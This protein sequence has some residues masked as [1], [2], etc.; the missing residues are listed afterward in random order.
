MAGLVIL[1]HF[2]T[3]YGVVAILWLMTIAQGVFLL[4]SAVNLLIHVS[5]AVRQS[6]RDAS[7]R[8]AYEPRAVVF[9]PCCGVD[10]RLR[11]TVESLGRQDYADYEIIF[12]FESAE[13]LAYAAVGQWI[14]G[15]ERPR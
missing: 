8:W 6:P 15:W 13:D 1:Q 4:R 3:I 9:L 12:T 5:R 2:P 14:A 10:E 7:G 11:Q